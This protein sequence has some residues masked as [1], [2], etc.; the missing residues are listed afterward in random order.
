MEGGRP[1]LCQAPSGNGNLPEERKLGIL[2]SQSYASKWIGHQPWLPVPAG[3]SMGCGRLDARRQGDAPSQT[4]P[5][6][7]N[8]HKNWDTKSGLGKSMFNAPT[9]NACWRVGTLPTSSNCYERFPSTACQ[10]NHGTGKTC[11]LD[12]QGCGPVCSVAMSWELEPQSLSPKFKCP[13][14]SDSC[15]PLPAL[16]TPGLADPPHP[17][18]EVRKFSVAYDGEHLPLS[19]DVRGSPSSSDSDSSGSNSG[20]SSDDFNPPDEASDCTPTAS[21]SDMISNCTDPCEGAGGQVARKCSILQM[22]VT[23]LS[24]NV[25]RYIMSSQ[26][27]ILL[28]Q[29]HRLEGKNYIK[30]LHKLGRKFHVYSAPAPIKVSGTQGGTMVLVRKHLHILDKRLYGVHSENAFWSVAI[31]R[32]RHKQV[33]FISVYLLP[34]DEARNI[35]TKFEVSMFLKC[36]KG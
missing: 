36:Y 17:V 33:A 19:H 22:N 15:P 26:H 2:K 23:S 13:G 9:N 14:V 32:F 24:I 4:A 10:L 1:R 16:D 34:D 11:C 27:D 18:P 29:E 12:E 7:C 35:R 28:L 30:A 6:P 20:L 31:V 21:A 25:I 3:T 8:T 5:C